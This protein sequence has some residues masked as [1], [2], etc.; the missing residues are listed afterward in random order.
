MKSFKDFKKED[1]RASFNVF[2]VPFENDVV[3]IKNS[4]TAVQ[5]KILKETLDKA[6]ET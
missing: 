3:Y 4:T 6:R 1:V 2:S 5:N